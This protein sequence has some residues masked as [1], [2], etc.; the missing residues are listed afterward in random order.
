MWNTDAPM[1]TGMIVAIVVMAVLAATGAFAV[2]RSRRAFKRAGDD[3]PAESR[4]DAVALAAAVRLTSGALRALPTPPWR[5]VYE[6]GTERLTGAEH[7]VLGP[8]GAFA[9]TTSLDPLPGEPDDDPD[10]VALASAAM[11]RGGLDD[12]LHRVRLSSAGLVVVHWGGAEPEAPPAVPG[13]HGVTHVDGRRLDE[14][15]EGLVDEAFTPT[16]VDLGWQAVVTA[17][18]R[19]DPLA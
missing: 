13:M 12:A 5:V 16:Q 3:S 14:W 18:G 19:P 4:T 2:Q 8:P 11:R 15:A 1:S 10:P 17:I 6:I 7:V 9:V